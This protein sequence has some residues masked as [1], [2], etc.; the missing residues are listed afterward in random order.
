MEIKYNNIQECLKLL[1][2]MVLVLIYSDTYL[3]LLKENK[4][5]K[6]EKAEDPSEKSTSNISQEFMQ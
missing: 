1:K 3:Q 4:N 5:S 2:I 6:G